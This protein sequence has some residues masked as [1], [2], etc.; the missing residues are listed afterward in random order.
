MLLDVAKPEPYNI[1]LAWKFRVPTLNL[2][3]P[4]PQ[5]GGEFSH[6]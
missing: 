6:T 2:F 1:F 5:F 3:L 4:Q